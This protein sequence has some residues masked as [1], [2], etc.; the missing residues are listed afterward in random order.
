MKQVVTSIGGIFF[1]VVLTAQI[2]CAQTTKVLRT[3]GP[4]Y[5]T[6]ASFFQSMTRLPYD[7]EPGRENA[8]ENGKKVSFST[9]AVSQFFGFQFNPYLA[10]GVGVNFEYWTTKTGTGFVP[11]YV[12][13]RVNMTDQKIAPHWYL[14]AGYATCWHI[15]S[16]PYAISTGAGR[17]LG[18]HGYTAGPMAET[19]FGLKASINSNSAFLVTVAGKV[20]ESS[21]RYYSGPE[22]PQGTKPSLVNTNSHGLYISVGLKAG[23]VF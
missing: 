6:S 23:I 7:V 22:L 3:R 21:L 8:V 19:G 9:I 12:D 14:N 4:M 2:S 15:D 1:M 5:I 17:M 13:F 18:I 10:L 20:Q 16:R 11:I